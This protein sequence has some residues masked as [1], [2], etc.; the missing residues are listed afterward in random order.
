[1]KRLYSLFLVP[2]IL[3]LVW[4][5]ISFFSIV[6]PLLLPSPS[7]V[8]SRIIEFILNGS[9]FPHVFATLGR[10]FTGYLMAIVIGIPLG[11]IV[12]Y[13]EKIYNYAEFIIDFFR[14]VPATALLPLFLLFFGIGNKS[15]VAVVVFAASLIIVINTMYGARNIKSLR[16]K[17]A[18]VF[19]A[20]RLTLF[21]KIILPDTL[22]WIFTGLRVAISLSLVLIIVT[23]MLIGT[24]TGLGKIIIDSQLLY[25]IPE[26]YAAIILTGVI[27]YVINQGV[28][29]TE[30]KVVH[31]AGK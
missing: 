22:P 26:M 27:G 8:F 28:Q 29:I 18:K 30:K 15:K 4:Y 11:L 9:I 16:I 13:Y 5:F 23:E 24:K 1:M 25:E 20:D 2:L 19:K 10:T 31:W 21:R 3:I 17:T 7:I 6:N 12:G 14:S